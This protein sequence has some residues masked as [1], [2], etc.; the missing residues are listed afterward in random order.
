[1]KN[2]KVLLTLVSLSWFYG[3]SDSAFYDWL[4]DRFD[5]AWNVVSWI[6][7][8]IVSTIEF[9]T[10]TIK[11]LFSYLSSAFIDIFWDSFVGYLSSYFDTIA[12]YMWW[13]WGVIFVILFMI[14]FLIMVFSFIM[15][16]LKWQIN[17]N[18]TLRRLEKQD[19]RKK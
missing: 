1:M 6:F 13:F 19:L 15:R 10:K 9:L 5:T 3:F 8:F 4:V 12:Q 7:T 18:A 2:L 16:L 11:S 14:T 17:Y